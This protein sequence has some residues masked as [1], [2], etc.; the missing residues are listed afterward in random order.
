M[1]RLLCAEFTKLFCCP[2]SDRYY[3][4]RSAKSTF[5]EAQTDWSLQNL[6]AKDLSDEV[7]PGV[8]ENKGTWS[9]ISREQGIF[10]GLIWGNKGCLYY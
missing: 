5:D 3:W 7:V 10:M 4:I 9:F 6:E 2:L 8:W 1:S